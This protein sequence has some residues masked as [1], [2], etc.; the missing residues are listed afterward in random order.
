MRV[1]SNP[2]PGGLLALL[3]YGVAGAQESDV[4]AAAAQEAAAQEAGAQDAGNQDRLRCIR[5]SRIDRTEVMDDQTIAFYLTGGRVYLN[6]LD[7]ACR[8]LG[9]NRPLAYETSTGQLCASDTITVIEDFAGVNAGDTCGLGEFVLTDEEDIE[10]LKG[11]R[12]PVEVEPEEVEVEV[13]E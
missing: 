2:L 11:G 13:D 3:V 12:E 5:L 8:N 9:R 1:G 4:P 7:R 6:R 10:V